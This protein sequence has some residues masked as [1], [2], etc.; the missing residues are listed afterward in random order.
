M[1]A[2]SSVGVPSSLKFVLKEKIINESIMICGSLC[3]FYLCEH[4]SP[5]GL[6]PRGKSGA[7]YSLMLLQLSV[8]LTVIFIVFSIGVISVVSGVHQQ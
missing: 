8:L 3:C 6:L 2:N 5:K 7:S 4:V 1:A